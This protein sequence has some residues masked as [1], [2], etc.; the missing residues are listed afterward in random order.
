MVNI[1]GKVN[2]ISAESITRE[3]IGEIGKISSN[4]RLSRFV[5]EYNKEFK[6]PRYPYRYFEDV[7]E[8]LILRTMKGP[9]ALYALALNGQVIIDLAT[10]LEQ[11]AITYI[12]ELFSAIPARKKLVED[13]VKFR[14][15]N[16]LANHLVTFKIWDKKDADNIEKLKEKKDGLAHKHVKIVSNKFNNGKPISITEIDLYQLTLIR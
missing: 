10:I 9:L 6:N 5:K 1:R 12:S 16:E 3:L 4:D 11:Y 13:L 7:S 14:F 2:R 8:P 15:L